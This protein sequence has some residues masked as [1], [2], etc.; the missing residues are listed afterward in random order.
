MSSLLVVFGR[1]AR[2]R[3]R[4]ATLR[5]ARFALLIFAVIA[6]IS[7]FGDS[8]A[9]AAG[10]GYGPGIGGPAAA[11]GGFSSIVTTH[12]FGVTGGTVSANVPGGEAELTVPDGA[13]SQPIQAIIT[14]PDLS[15]INAALPQLGFSGYSAIAGVGISIDDANGKPITSLFVHPLTLTIT[16]SGIDAG[17]L[18]VE[19]TSLSTA[20]TL[21]AAVFTTGSVTVSLAADPDFA[22]LAPSS[23]ASATSSASPPASGSSPPTIVEGEQFTKSPGGSIV[24]KTLFAI[25]AVLIVAAGVLMLVL[26]RRPPDSFIPR[27]S[28]ASAPPKQRRAPSPTFTP[29]HARS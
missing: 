5:I 17:D 16:G 8:A 11:P 12:A 1:A 19:F 25:L 26:R 27:H 28:A 22:V 21:Q 10:G 14:A 6:T 2:K 20:A 29:K 15:G 13:F 18:L 7:L 4:P 23:A 3:S 24:D 9:H